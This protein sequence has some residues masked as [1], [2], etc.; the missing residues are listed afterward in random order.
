MFGR[1]GMT[2]GGQVADAERVRVYEI[3]KE[4]G[5]SSKDLVA[6]VRGL[7]IEVR[8]HM[9]VLDFEDAQR[10]R[11]AIQ[12]ERVATREV[13]RISA[14]VIRRRSKV[15][16]TAV[17]EGTAPAPQ[18]GTSAP[19][20]GAAE[21]L[22]TGG[23]RVEAPV[24]ASEAPADAPAGE[25]VP[26]SAAMIEAP[27]GEEREN[28]A[29]VTTAQEETEA[30]A[31]KKAPRTGRPA[32]KREIRFA[33]G[34]TPPAPGTYGGHGPVSA[35]DKEAG[36]TGGDGAE[37]QHMSAAE[38]ARMM[39]PAQP[40][41]PKVV[42]TDLDKSGR[43][44]PRKDLFSDR[45]RGP[46]RKSRKRI[47]TTKKSGKKT[48]ITMPAEHKRVIRVEDQIG[49]GEMARQM[50]VKSTEVLKKL[51]AMGMT[52]I[53]INQTLDVDAASILASE[54]GYE[55]E[56]VAFREDQVLDQVDDK[57]EDLQLRAPVVTVMGHVD[58]GKTSLLDG[59]R[60]ADVA[61]GE[62]GGITQHIGAYRV[63]AR[64]SDVVFLDTPGH[65]AFTQMRARGTQCT[66]IV[67]LVVAADD[68]VMPTTLEALDHARDANVPIV[69]AINKMDLPD[70]NA[71]RVKTELAERNLVPDDWGGET[72]Y[73]PVS[74]KTKDGIENLLEAVVLQAELLELTANPGKAAKG[75]IVEGRMDRARGAVATVLVQ[76]GTLNVGDTVVTG[77]HVGKVRALLD[78]RG[79]QIETAGPS[80]P[81]EILG[82]SGVPEPGDLLNAVTDEKAARQVVEHRR[83]KARRKG[84][85]TSATKTYEELLGEI[86]AGQA[87]ELK[88]LVKAD[89]HGSAEAVRDSLQKLSTERVQANVI[90]AGVGGIHETDVNLAKAAGAII[91][92]FSVRPAG[93][94]TQLAEHEGVEIR[95]YD[96]IY[97]LLDD[98]KEMMRGLLPKDRREK[99]LGRL[100]VRQ[101][102]VIPKIG[103]IA[104]CFVV[105]GKVSRAA[106]LRLIRD[107]VKIYEGKV[108]SLR[109]FKDDV[110]EVA[111]GYE[112]GLSIDGY[113]EIQE[114]DVIEAYEVEEVAP[115]LS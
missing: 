108:G 28:E 58:H 18:E 60:N 32:Q 21:Q 48:E 13:K 50:G 51:W 22:A 86:Q 23:E 69:V 115:T 40:N 34:F 24:G 4:V 67:I 11:Q 26:Q 19:S 66:D 17:L 46:Q 98:T 91:V 2:D 27:A 73:I 35:K 25:T 44:D 37:P 110:K 74:A 71:D 83:S 105:D 38:V 102:F 55:I 97:E 16:P 95:I 64:D 62:A 84:A 94:A 70:A 101:V 43:R 53:T 36:A 1:Q 85:G 89:V 103:A 77:E 6:K 78:D 57:P 111:Q 104:G 106:H 42:I 87:K 7:G 82:L 80:T 9:S 56:N 99:A 14:T 75:T 90:S 45:F 12:Q 5:V 29:A 52:G 65:E 49:V 47:T 41:R 68:G 113:K 92:G 39:A 8:N 76:E 15:S 114:G 93:K 100:E 81:V 3:A 79:R 31:K 10:I 109:R 30:P 61:A 59:I 20:A 88:L 112:C 72:Q 33:P 96:V 107:N 54:F 63:R